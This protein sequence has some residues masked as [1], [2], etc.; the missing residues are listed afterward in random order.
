MQQAGPIH[1]QIRA[2]IVTN[3]LFGTG[4]VEYDASLISEGV[5]DSTSVLEMVLFLEEQYGIPVSEDEVVPEHFDSINA[6]AAFIETK[7]SVNSV[8]LAG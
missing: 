7:Q 6:L 5:L 8:R 1:E 3:V 4:D 2:Y